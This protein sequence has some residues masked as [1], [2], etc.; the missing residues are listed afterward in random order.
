MRKSAVRTCPGA[1]L[2]VKEETVVR[3]VITR[4]QTVTVEKSQCTLSG[5]IFRTN[6]YAVCDERK[7]AGSAGPAQHLSVTE[8]KR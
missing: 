1:T 2:F 6:Q 8:Q 4:G 7:L 5:R 3:N